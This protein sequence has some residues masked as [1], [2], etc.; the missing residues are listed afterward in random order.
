VD[1]AAEIQAGLAYL[2]SLGRFGMKLTLDR[3]QALLELLGEP[4]HTFPVVHIAGTNGKGSTAR[5]I[6]A[7]MQS[8]G[9]KTGL[10]T[11]PHLIRYNERIRINGEPIADESLLDLIN[12]VKPLVPQVTARHGHPTEFEI[13]TAM[14]F[15]HFALEKVD[16][17]VIEVGLG[18]LWDSTNVVK[19]LLSVITPVSMDHMS[20]LGDTLAE[21]AEQKAGIIKQEV[22]VVCAPQRPEAADVIAEAAHAANSPV[23][24]V[25]QPEEAVPTQG[26]VA[27]LY[28]ETWNR[29][30][31]VFHLDGP[32]ERWN[33]ISISML[34]QHQLV[35]A[36]VA[37]TCCQVLAE[38]GFAVGEA[39]VREAFVHT[40]WPGRLDVVADN[41]IVIL[42]GAH[43][44][45]GARVLRRSLDEL[46]PNMQKA[47]VIGMLAE[48]QV[49]EVLDTLIPCADLLVCTAP[50]AGR[51]APA[52]SQE[53]AALAQQI[54]QRSRLSCVIIEQ[55]DVFTA[56]QV[57]KQKVGAQGLVCVCGSLY[58]L[59]E[60][61]QDFQL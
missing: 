29:W 8:A 44:V 43:N 4:Q 54:A 56:L 52:T 6:A 10:F 11:S 15:L 22:P 31:G 27:T 42:D 18:G 47:L 20:R 13:S 1:K 32:L 16:I 45:D 53:L 19:P 38:L 55:D 39:D 23:Y 35:N 17:A 14:A 57:A 33:N 61:L 41:P 28:P 48:K 7:A 2:T 30:G 25:K 5:L 60:L 51:T 59:G 12:H 3:I 49:T 24:W 26:Q 9:F 50:A 46:F 40:T 34:G 36:A 21:I 37:A 58:L